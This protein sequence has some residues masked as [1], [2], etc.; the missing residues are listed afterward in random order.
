[1]GGYWTASES[2]IHAV[3]PSP[4]RLPIAS[5]SSCSA[6]GPAGV[7]AAIRAA[8]LGARTALLTAAEFGGMAANDGPVPVR[9]LAFAA[10]LMRDARQLAQYGIAT[11]EPALHYDRLLARM[12]EIVHEVSTHSALRERTDELGVT[13]YEQAGA[14]RFTGPHTIETEGGCRLE[15][16]KFVLCT[17]GVSRRLAIPGVELTHTHSDAWK[18]SGVPASLLVVGGGDTG[19]QIASMFHAF[20]SKVQLFERGPRILRAADEIS[21]GCCLSRPSRVWRTG[22]RTLRRDHVVRADADRRAHELP[23]RPQR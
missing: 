15:A 11:T 13:V 23:R 18:L 19:V 5:T 3:R 14:A 16:E 2:V 1:M 17:G 10:R 22:T 20:G 12:R 21:R 9:T 8:E 7:L 4:D 6:P